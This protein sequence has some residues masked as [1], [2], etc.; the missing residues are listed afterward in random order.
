V[1]AVLPVSAL[2]RA[3][4]VP[5]KVGLDDAT[6]AAGIGC[7]VSSYRKSDDSK[8]HFYVFLKFI[9]PIDDQGLAARRYATTVRSHTGYLPCA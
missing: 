4:S 3:G 6:C 1:T 2:L 5:G 7:L 8:K 9:F